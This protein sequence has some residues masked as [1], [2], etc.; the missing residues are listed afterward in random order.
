[1]RTRTWALVPLAVVLS[2][3]TASGSLAAPTIRCEQDPTAPERQICQTSL[4]A[5][6]APLSPAMVRR[7]A[8]R[9]LRN[10]FQSWRTTT[11]KA[12]R[13]ANRTPTPG[14]ANETWICAARWLTRYGVRHRD[15]EVVN[16]ATADVRVRVFH[17]YRP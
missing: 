14:P 9:G 11:Q 12:M 17:P 7:W 4:P 10:E 1:M 8:N 13:C 6:P 5:H 3:A 16:V 15:V 2:T